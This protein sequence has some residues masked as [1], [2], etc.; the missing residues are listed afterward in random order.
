MYIVYP[1]CPRDVS[2]IIASLPQGK[3]WDHKKSL[4]KN[5]SAL[6]LAF[7]VSTAVPLKTEEKQEVRCKW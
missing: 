2:V 4:R 3:R 5:L 6:G 1:S 7:D